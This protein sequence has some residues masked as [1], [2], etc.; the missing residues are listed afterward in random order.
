[1]FI[2]IKTRCSALHRKC[3]I[4]KISVM[5][6]Y[7][8]EISFR[9]NASKKKIAKTVKLC[10]ATGK[11]PIVCD[12]IPLYP[13]EKRRVLDIAPF[14]DFLLMNAF[15]HIIKGKERA[16][17]IDKNGEFFNL[18]EK[19]LK[20]VRTLYVLTSAA[21]KYEDVCEHLLSRLG[22]S[23][24]IIENVNPLFPFSAVFSPL[25]SDKYCNASV[26][27]GKGGFQICQDEVIFKDKRFPFILAAAIHLCIGTK[28][29]QTAL[30]CLLQCGNKKYSPD[31]L[32]VKIKDSRVLP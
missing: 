17:I 11:L 12:N 8:F 13:K 21:K 3:V 30:P 9:K 15:C 28:Q 18:I 7:Y 19:P 29:T 22:V 32:R 26:K 2:Y 25:N 16:L 1:M 5:G 27:I 24:V 23:P 31:A 6:G 20:S 4:N 10:D 14:Y